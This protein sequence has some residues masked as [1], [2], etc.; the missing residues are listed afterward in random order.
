LS[1]IDVLCQRSKPNFRPV[2]DHSGARETIIAGRPITTHKP[3]SRGALSQPIGVGKGG[4]GVSGG[5]GTRAP[6]LKKG[7]KIGKIFFGKLSCKIRAF[8]GKF[9]KFSGKYHKR[10]K[11][12]KYHPTKDL[13]M[14]RKL[15]QWGPGRAPAKNGFYAYFR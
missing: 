12:H 10:H 15:P 14:R 7:E 1:Q 8:W 13:G 9:L 11:Y 2:E 4:K 5:C 6:T 3:L